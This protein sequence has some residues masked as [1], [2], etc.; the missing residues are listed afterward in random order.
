MWTDV[1][2]KNR[3]CIYMNTLLG[4]AHYFSGTKL[5]N[6]WHEKNIIFENRMLT[7]R[8][9]RCTCMFTSQ[10]KGKRKKKEKNGKWAGATRHADG[11]GHSHLYEA[12]YAVRRTS[13]EADCSEDGR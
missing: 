11:P 6:N 7:L 5:N 2:V 12:E 4:H 3:D 1:V 9:V 10:I 13:P 8:N